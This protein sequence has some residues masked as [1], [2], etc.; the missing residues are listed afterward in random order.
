MNP[1]GPRERGLLVGLILALAPGSAMQAQTLRIATWDPELSRSGPGI[2]LRDIR[3]TAPQVAAA[4]QVIEGASP[5]ILLLTGF[6]W[7]Q[8]QRAL[9]AFNAKLSEPYPCLFAS[10]PNTGRPSGADLDDNGKINEPR[11]A[12]GYGRFTGQAGMALLSRLPIRTDEVRDFSDLLWRDLPGSRIGT[13]GV[14]ASARAV[15]RLST[16]AHWDVPLVLPEGT[17]LHLL[18]FAATVPV[19][20]P[21]IFTGRLTLAPRCCFRAVRVRPEGPAPGWAGG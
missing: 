18:A 10:R 13:A 3:K 17:V 2:L 11:D 8:G 6:D 15:Q 12:Q 19:H 20:D 7:D 5:D 16:T 21:A 14:N 9:T 1:A 4:V